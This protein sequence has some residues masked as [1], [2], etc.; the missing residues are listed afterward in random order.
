MCEQGVMLIGVNAVLLFVCCGLS[1]ARYP[2]WRE[3]ESCGSGPRTPRLKFLPDPHYS[4]MFY[5]YIQ[6]WS[7][8]C[9]GRL[10]GI[11]NAV[12]VQLGNMGF[13]QGIITM[14][15]LMVTYREQTHTFNKPTE[16]QE[17]INKIKGE[18]G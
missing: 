9:A 11:L 16:A 5:I 3:G 13:R 10:D 15:K 7:K 1:F 18:A 2:L 8:V 14:A 12:A 17:F 4:I 6:S